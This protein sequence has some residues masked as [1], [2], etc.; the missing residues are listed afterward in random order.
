MSSSTCCTIAGLHSG[1]ELV[2]ISTQFCHRCPPRCAGP[3]RSIGVTLTEVEITGY[4][5]IKRLRLPL[6]QLTVLTGGNGVGKTNLYRSL[7]LLQASALGT[8]SAEIAREGG[9]GSV[10]WAG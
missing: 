4:R 10:F 8:L 1:S 2:A 7:E 5:S 3:D 9:L 6:R